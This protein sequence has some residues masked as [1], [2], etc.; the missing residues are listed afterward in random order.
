MTQKKPMSDAELAAFEASQDFEA[1]L[2]QSVREMGAATFPQDAAS[3][4]PSDVGRK[5]QAPITPPP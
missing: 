2:V 4:G 1:L 5:D 3:C